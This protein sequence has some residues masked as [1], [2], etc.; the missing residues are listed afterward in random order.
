MRLGVSVACRHG[1]NTSILLGLLALLLQ[2]FPGLA[3]AGGLLRADPA[4]DQPLIIGDTALAAVMAMPVDGDVTTAVVGATRDADWLWLGQ[5]PFAAAAALALRTSRPS[6]N[7][8]CV[9]ERTCGEA[10]PSAPGIDEVNGP[11]G[12]IEKTGW[13][14]FAVVGNRRMYTYPTTA[15]AKRRNSDDPWM[16]GFGS[17]IDALSLF[18]VDSG[19]SPYFAVGEV[20]IGNNQIDSPG[21]YGYRARLMVG[22]RF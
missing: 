9:H 6:L 4:A 11:V 12:P 19:R 13:A 3:D 15:K 17:Q 2:L 10:P 22:V 14:A 16:F 5:I 8:E 1:G 7:L 20:G 21:S 18:G